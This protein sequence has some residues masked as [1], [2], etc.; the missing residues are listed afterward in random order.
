MQTNAVSPQQARDTMRATLTLLSTLCTRVLEKLSAALDA[1]GDIDMAA[2]MALGK[3]LIDAA[4][5]INR[6]D[7][8]EQRAAATTLRREQFEAR[9]AKELRTQSQADQQARHAGVSDGPIGPDDEGAG[10]GVNDMHGRLIFQAAA[11]YAP[12]LLEHIQQGNQPGSLPEFT[13]ALRCILQECG[14]DPDNKSIQQ[15]LI[16]LMIG[17]KLLPGI[18]TY[19]V[20]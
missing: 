19:T 15:G 10:N 2:F 6:M 17:S 13:P 20:A 9:C 11:L 3:Q 4:R 14:M 5:E 16:N 8:C 18:K 1:T 7:S 12:Q